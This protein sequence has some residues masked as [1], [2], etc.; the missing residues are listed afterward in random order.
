MGRMEVSNLASL[1]RFV[2]NKEQQPEAE[3]H[4]QDGPQV[5]SFDSRCKL[6]EIGHC[7]ESR[8]VLAYQ[9]RCDQEEPRIWLYHEGRRQWFYLTESFTK[10]F[11]MML[12][13]LGL[14]LWQYC[15]VG[16][17]LPTWVEQV[18][19]LV[20]PHLLPTTPKPKESLST[21]QWNEGPTNVIDPLIFKSKENKQRSSKK[22]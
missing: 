9:V 16:L 12:V 8:V 21:F 20:G 13:H 6:F 3:S 4:R 14:P 17:P 7:G 11:R 1:K 15:V 19:F 5:P 18:F 10:Y 2:S 22:K